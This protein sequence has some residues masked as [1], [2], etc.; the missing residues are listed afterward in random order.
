MKRSIYQISLLVLFLFSSSVSFSQNTWNLVGQDNDNKVINFGVKVL[1]N[2]IYTTSST[3]N[4]GDSIPYVNTNL[5]Q[6]DNNGNIIFDS[7]CG[8]INQTFV[9]YENVRSNFSF[10]SFCYP[11][12]FR[13]PN[14]PSLGEKPGFLILDTAY[15][16][17]LNYISPFNNDTSIYFIGISHIKKYDKKYLITS[18]LQHSVT[19]QW[20]NDNW[21]SWNELQLIDSL[22]NVFASRKI[23][24]GIGQQDYQYYCNTVHYFDNNY[25]IIVNKGNY[26]QW[27]T[28]PTNLL[29][30]KMD[31]LLNVVDSFNTTTNNWYATNSSAVFPN[32]D[33]VVGGVYVDAWEPDGDVWQKKYLRK[34][35][36]N[37]NIIW[38]KYFGLRNLNTGITKLMITSDGNIVGCGIDGLLSDTIGIHITGCIFKF[39]AN[40]DSVWMHNYQAIDDPLY[41]DNNE[42]LDI[43]E[44]PDGGFVACGK[45]VAFNPFTQRGWIMRVDANG[46]LTPDCV[47]STK[48][49]EN[50]NEFIVYPNPATD[51]IHISNANQIAAYQIFQ[52]DGKQVASGNS[53]PINS[54]EFTK[55]IYLIKIQTKNNQ[56]FT[57]KI[58]KQ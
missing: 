36:K 55:G 3:I 9:L 5:I 8:N 32:G 15:N 21:C 7:L 4:W 49:Y 18:L 14:N 48:E 10:G 43:D 17:E 38:T 54:N 26:R 28:N 2:K 52:F 50:N 45:A 24:G 34:F 12:S 47:S 35:D 19:Y 20:A 56:I 53:F 16:T 42:L 6:Y 37:L 58:I 41:G 57:Q 30:Y 1:N 31:T 13:Y 22:G 23:G 29:I 25:Y 27:Q 11:I 40:G 44:M 51:L 33:F 39:T 46:C